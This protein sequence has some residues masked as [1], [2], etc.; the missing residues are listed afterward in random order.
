MSVSRPPDVV[1]NT[2]RESLIGL[3]IELERVPRAGFGSASR[4]R[5]RACTRTAPLRSLTRR[6]ERMDVRQ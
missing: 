6:S 2:R 4:F 5:S 1:L 3:W